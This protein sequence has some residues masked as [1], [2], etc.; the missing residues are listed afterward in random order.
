M[1]NTVLG[2]IKLCNL[3]KFYFLKITQFNI[4]TVCIQY[5]L[6]KAKCTLILTSLQNIT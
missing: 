5:I 1:L 2:H 4:Y 6:I 3:S